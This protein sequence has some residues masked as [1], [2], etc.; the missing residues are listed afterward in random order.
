MSGVN[1]NEYS[2][3]P[4]A[5]IPTC[6]KQVCPGLLIVYDTSLSQCTKDRRV[7]QCNKCRTAVPLY[8]KDWP[9]IAYRVAHAG[10]IIDAE[11]SLLEQY[12]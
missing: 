3:E 5:R 6:P 7:Y 10:C 12:T 2:A 1:Y 8:K 11:G 4:C 9:R